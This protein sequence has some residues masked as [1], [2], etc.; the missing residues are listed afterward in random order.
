MRRARGYTRWALA[1]LL[2][3]LAL[4]PV[5]QA[6]A[7]LVRPFQAGAEACQGDCAAFLVDLEPLA[8]T[9]PLTDALERQGFAVE[10]LERPSIL[11]FEARLDAFF[12]RL[13]REGVR[14][15]VLAYRGPLVV[16]EGRA[17]LP[18]REA[19]RLSG[20]DG[21][22]L[23]AVRLPGLGDRLA[24]SGLESAVLIIEATRRPTGVPVD[25]DFPGVATPET[26]LIVTPEGGSAALA[27][28]IGDPALPEGEA[29]RLAALRARLGPDAEIRRLNPETTVAAL[30]AGEGAP[31]S[32]DRALDP[33]SIAAEQRR[34]DFEDIAANPTLERLGAFTR[35]HCPPGERARA[36]IE[37]E[38]QIAALERALSEQVRLCHRL[39]THP[40]D[41][42]TTDTG[43]PGDRV[44]ARR[45]LVPC[46]EALDRTP[47]DPRLN[48][49]Y[50][51]V[52]DILRNPGFAEHY[53]RAVSQGY[54]IAAYG[55]SLA[56]LEGRVSLGLE[57]AAELARSAAEAEIVE[58]QRLYALLLRRGIGTAPNPREARRY[59]ERAS[60]AAPL[61]QIDLAEL[62]LDESGGLGPET[63]VDE[64]R[65]GTF[66]E[67][68]RLLSDAIR[69]GL[70][71]ADR[72][73]A[74]ALLA[75]INT[76]LDAIER[77][78]TPTDPMA[79]CADIL[80]YE[81]LD[82]FGLFSLVDIIGEGDLFDKLDRHQRR[83][84]R[85]LDIEGAVQA[86]EPMFGQT[87]VPRLKTRYAVLLELLDRPGRARDYGQTRG[88]AGALYAQAA[89]EGEAQAMFFHGLRTRNLD[90][91]R[92]PGAFVEGQR[93]LERAHRAGV[94]EATFF[95]SLPHILRDAPLG[96][97][98]RADPNRGLE[99][100]LSIGNRPIP[101]VKVM[102]ANIL[103]NPGQWGIARAPASPAIIQRYLDEARQL[104]VEF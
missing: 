90:P 41:P 20:A 84:L 97:G 92:H 57:R 2:A 26:L 75:R 104:G 74:E 21:A 53:E 91:N 61:A 18:G 99:L 78:R 39:A 54:A 69:R 65:E 89:D 49:Q 59:L 17:A 66:E 4:A 9:D 46:R 25:P 60:E 33:A 44:D 76:R 95:L 38:R 40:D 5:P 35:Q 6:A 10:R 58:A 22:R 55:Y 70:V 71:D 62:I 42:A 32:L 8:G 15:A 87:V 98:F 64:R 47:E 102:L 100:M 19:G 34:L 7:D 94:A 24:A 31:T 67:V 1:G 48:Y 81:A 52:L 14:H 37:A 93:W 83:K 51:R 43:V 28:L 27:G 56:I 79:A 29:E 36:C 103:S 80:T 96:S 3:G 101:I 50:A 88:G 73:E 72:T 11:A 77:Q 68:Q 63:D 30:P 12:A 16:R 86:C 13:G 85:R 82:L 45:A 23:D